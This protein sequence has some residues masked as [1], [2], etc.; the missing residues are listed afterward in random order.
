MLLLLVLLPD[1]VAG[2]AAARVGLLVLL[3]LLRLQDARVLAWDTATGAQLAA[4]AG[5]TN[6]ITSLDCGP[7]GS[8][9]GDLLFSADEDNTVFVRDRAA[10]ATGSSGGTGSGSDKRAKVEGPSLG[11]AWAVAVSPSG[12]HV[13]AGFDSGV[14]L[15][16]VAGSASGGTAVAAAV[17]TPLP[18]SLAYPRAP[19]P[20]AA[21]TLATPPAAAG[22]VAATAAVG[23]AGTAP[24]SG[25]SRGCA[26]CSAG[27]PGG[28]GG[29]LG[30][31]V[32]RTAV[33]AWAQGQDEE[34]LQVQY[35]VSGGHPPAWSQSIATRCVAAC[36]GCIAACGAWHAAFACLA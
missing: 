18:A 30:G 34:A 36:A 26:C 20:P 3:L 22:A 19:L 8:A 31:R 2:I 28:G 5:H 21:A 32:V 27:C 33:L 24:A 9:S 23:G 13:A 6:N 35:D 25:G 16:G 7:A 1:A 12:N 15:F 14:A 4:L 29:G 11:R 10:A 17:A